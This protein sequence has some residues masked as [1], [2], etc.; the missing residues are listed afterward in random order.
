ML[1]LKLTD[2]CTAPSVPLIFSWLKPLYCSAVTML[3]LHGC[4]ENESHLWE[5]L[6]DHRTDVL[7]VVEVQRCINLIQNV[8]G[9]RLEPEQQPRAMLRTLSAAEKQRRT[10]AGAVPYRALMHLCIWDD[11]R[12]WSCCM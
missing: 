3:R 4:L 9:G 8:D 7:C 2:D 1:H 5:V 12:A 11:S 6:F 10:I